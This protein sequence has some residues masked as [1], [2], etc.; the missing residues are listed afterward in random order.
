MLDWNELWAQRFGP[1]TAPEQHAPV[2]PLD[3]VRASRY[4]QAALDREVTAVATAPEGVRNDTLNRAGFSLAQLVA[5]GHI[6]EADV[7]AQLSAAARHA[8][9]GEREIA[10]TLASSLGAGSALPR[11]VPDL[12]TPPDVT[13]LDVPTIGVN[14]DKGAG[15]DDQGTELVTTWAPVD[16]RPFLDGTHVPEAP[17]L[18]CRTDGAALLYAGRVHS[19]HGESESGKSMVA[20]AEAAAR[21]NAGGSVLYVDFESDAAAVVA[22]LVELGARRDA[23]ADGFSYLRP[24]TDPRRFVHEREAL[25]EVLA[26]PRALVVIDG[27]TDAL[28]VFGLK[29]EDNDDLTTFMRSLPKLM[30]TRTGGAVLLI[31]HVTKNADTRG[32]FAIGGQAKMAGLD[33]AAFVVEMTEALG[34]GLCGAITLRIAKDRP[35]GIRPHCGAWRKLD[36]TQEAAHIVVDS[37]AGDGAIAVAIEPPRTGTSP[38][39]GSE[40]RPTRLMERVSDF[41]AAAV[42]PMSLAV[43]QQAVSGRAT[44]VRHAVELLVREGYVQVHTGPRNA[45]LHTLVRPYREAEDVKSDR[46]LPSVTGM[47]SPQQDGQDATTSDHF[48][49]LPGSGAPPRPTASPPLRGKR[50]TGRGAGQGDRFPSGKACE[51]CGD[52]SVTP[53]VD[54]VTGGLCRACYAQDDSAC[55]RPRDRGQPE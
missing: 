12:P 52:E 7:R 39:G 47:D 50:W 2:T 55:D 35:G 10:N 27:V 1:R 40:H 33:G 46:H 8:G 28:S 22:R 38:E 21:L 14:D 9:L 15:E 48:P 54:H 29:T 44:S 4:A 36:R 5:A 53:A 19:L 34:R 37:T 31:D 42:E 45:L 32:R 49:P 11:I 13:T 16:L 6:G 25:G 23:I 3:P 20:Q 26:T 30:A 41:V 17:T 18:M 51:R 43:I 24:E